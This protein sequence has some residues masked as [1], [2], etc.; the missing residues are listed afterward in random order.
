[1]R[2][3]KKRERL[4]FSLAT[5]LPIHLRE[6]TKLDQSSLLRMEFQREIR[7]PFPKLSQKALGVFALLKADHQIISVADNSSPRSSPSA[8]FRRH[9]STHRSNT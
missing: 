3:P 2:E 4:R 6:P 8:A 1:V 9:A 5:L 7:Q